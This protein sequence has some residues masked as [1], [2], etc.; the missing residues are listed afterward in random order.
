MIRVTTLYASG[1]GVS[2]AYYTGYLT[3]ADGEQ[4]GVWAGSQAAGLGLAG[5]VTTEALE[6]LLSGHHPTTGIQLGRALED[7]VDRHGNTI[8]AV[9]GYD[10][11]LSAPKSLSV[12]WGLTGDDGFA[13]CHDVAVNAVVRMIERYGSTTRIR[14]NGSRLHPET[15]GLT[16]GVFRQSTSRA[17]DPQLHTHVVIS[18]KVQTADGRGYALDA[19]MLK[20]YQQAFGY[21]YQ[22]VLRAE[23]TARYGVVFDPIVNGQA[24]IAGVPTELLEQFSKRSREIGTEM[25]DKL[26]DFLDRR[27]SHGASVGGVALRGVGRDWGVGVAAVDMESDGRAAHDLRHRDPATRTRRNQ[28]GERTRRV[29]EHGARVVHRSGSDHRVDVSVGVRWS[30]GVDRA[31]HEPVHQRAHLDPGGAHRDVGARRPGRRSDT[32]THNR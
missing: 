7:R 11:T 14:S 32:V 16:V 21:L 31:D 23:V 13:E 27:G 24:E 18:S 4:S 9:A 8:K 19:L 30:V 25:G 2:A 17:D 28:L 26:A 10:A 29:G 3:K 22:S 20:K 5:E 12:L 6:A 15:Q 1:A